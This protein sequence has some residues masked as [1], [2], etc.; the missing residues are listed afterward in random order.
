M[1]E[2]YLSTHNIPAGAV[3][4]HILR[5]SNISQRDLATN[6]GLPPQRIN[7]YIHGKRR[8]SVDVSFRLEKALSIEHKGFFYILQSNHDI[9]SASQTDHEATPDLTK[10]RKSIFWDTDLSRINWNTNSTSIIQRIF[11]Y[12]DPSSIDEI[13]RYYG[14]D[15]IQAVLAQIT[16]PRLKSRRAKNAQRAGL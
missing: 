15:K 14:S 10:I 11:E 7:D 8:I 4:Q 12:G 9:F 2:R 16:D 13:T 5:R 1:Y 3:L 6:T